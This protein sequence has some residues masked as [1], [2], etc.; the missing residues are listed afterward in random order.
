MLKEKTQGNLT[1]EEDK[2]IDVVLYN[3]RLR[4]VAAI[5]GGDPAGG[6]PG[7]NLEV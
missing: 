4:F 6:Q 3:L 5:S 7:P 1:E 2:Y